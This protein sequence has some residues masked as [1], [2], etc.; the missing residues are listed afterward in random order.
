[1]YRKICKNST[2]CTSE[3]NKKVIEDME[4]TSCSQ[5]FHVF[6]WQKIVV[7]KK[8]V[9]PM[10][11]EIN[12]PEGWR[13]PVKDRMEKIESKSD[14]ETASNAKE[15]QKAFAEVD[16]IAA[17][18]DNLT[19]KKKAVREEKA[20]EVENIDPFTD[21]KPE[22]VQ[23][24][25]GTFVIKDCKIKSSTTVRMICVGTKDKRWALDIE[26][27]PAK[28]ARLAT[29]PNILIDK[30]IKVEYTGLDNEGRPNEPKYLAIV[31]Q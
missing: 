14:I 16:N 12:K 30:S 19:G 10:P 31:A 21:S 24:N 2:D 11:T 18:I 1:M 13:E 9:V 8:S 28:V 5:C 4:I 26:S 27:E 15:M 3:K 22:Q 20:A 17:D 23:V 7:D 6:E 29:N 25:E